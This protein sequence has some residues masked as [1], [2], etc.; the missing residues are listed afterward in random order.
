MIERY[1]LT[2]SGMFRDDDG[3]WVRYE[4]SQEARRYL[5]KNRE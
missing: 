2:M 5:E 3:D 4:E 1:R